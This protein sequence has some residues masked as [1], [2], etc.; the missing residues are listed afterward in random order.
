MWYNAS[1]HRG[2]YKNPSRRRKMEEL[3]TNH[4]VPFTIHP[5]PQHPGA[6]PGPQLCETNPIY[7]T[8]GLSPASMP[9]K[10]AKRTHFPPR[11]PIIHYSL[12]TT[13]YCQDCGKWGYFFLDRWRRGGIIDYLR[14]TIY[15]FGDFFVALWTG[16]VWVAT[17]DS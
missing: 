14:M 10:C 1:Q 7:R 12:S 11:G 8:P 6:P 13:H 16:G 15:Y 2:R 17:G 9:R 4:K 5:H 3:S